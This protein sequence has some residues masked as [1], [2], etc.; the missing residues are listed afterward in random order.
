MHVNPRVS[1]MR[2]TP[3]ITERYAEHIR[4]GRT[5]DRRLR[6]HSG[7]SVDTM[8]R[9][10]VIVR[11]RVQ[12]VGFRYS[13][14]ATAR[15]HEVRGWVTNRLDG[16]VEAVFEGDPDAVGALVEWMRTGP[17]W[18]HVTGVD[19]AEEPSAGETTFEI[20]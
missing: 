5:R 11:G 3:T 16:T 2:P 14:A 4:V 15:M 17:A 10:R 13:C 6:A 8:I 7:L 12:G 19:V 20:R 18:A 1:W 9:R